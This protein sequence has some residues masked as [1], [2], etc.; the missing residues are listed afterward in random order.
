MGRVTGADGGYIVGDERLIPD[1]GFVSYTRQPEDPHAAYNPIAPD[2]AVEVL[3]PSD[4]PYVT[5][6]KIAS[7]THAGTTVWL[8]DPEQQT[9]EIYSPDVA[10][11]TLDNSDTL[12]GGDILPGFT[13][14]VK[15]IFPAQPDTDT[16]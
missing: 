6:L 5:R 13:L 1:V 10:P 8:I 11:Q 14:P 7:Y 12:N 4:S 16:L 15:D 3:S 2:L 9:V